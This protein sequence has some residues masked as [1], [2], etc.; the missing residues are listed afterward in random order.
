MRNIFSG[1][2]LPILDVGITESLKAR[3]NKGAGAFNE[4]S[5]GLLRGETINLALNFAA[6]L[7]CGQR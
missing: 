4:L 1:Y 6:G 3:A 2:Y 7:N 5:S